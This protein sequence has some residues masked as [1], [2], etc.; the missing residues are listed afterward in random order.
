[1]RDIVIVHMDIGYKMIGRNKP[2]T[3]KGIK[4]VPCQRCGKPSTGQWQVCSLNNRWIGICAECDTA[5]NRLVL[6]F[7][8]I[9]DFKRII[10]VYKPT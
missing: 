7:M 4:R 2:Y 9:K 1:M 5:L 3:S 6:E 10:G 8:K